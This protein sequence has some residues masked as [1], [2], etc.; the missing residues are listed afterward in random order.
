[1]FKRNFHRLARRLPSLVAIVTLLAFQTSSLSIAWA[2]NAARGGALPQPLPLFPADN[3]WNLD[4]S[5]WPVDSNSASFISFINNGGT[6][7]LH[8]DFGGNAGSGYA[9]Y[10]M[11]YA[12]VTSVTNADLKAVQ[13]DY[14]DESDGVDHS[15]NTSFPFY[16]IPSEAIT[17]P[18]WIEGGDPGN[19]D[20]RSSEDRHLLIVDKDRNYLYELYNVF[21][22]TTQGKWFAGSG[23]FFD[24]NTNSRRPDG[25]TSADAAGLAILPGLV[26]YDEVYDPNAEIRHALRVTVRATNGYVYPASHRAGS[27]ASAL[28][29]G[30]RLRLKAS[31][32]ITQRTGDPNVQK[33]FRA[34]QKYG[35][36]VADNGSDMYITGT[37][38]TRWNNDILNPAF[39]NVSA[40][41]FEVIQLGY[42]PAQTAQPNLSSLVLN[43]S[44]ITGGQNAT[45]TVTL[46]ATAPSGSVAV[47]LSSA[48]SAASVPSSV[49]IPATSSS[50]NF[51]ITTTAV[52]ATTVGNITAT[53]S[54][55][56]KSATLTVNPPAPAAISSLT[57][58]PST[59]VGGSTATGTV[60]LTKAAPAGGIVVN[61]TSSNSTR[62]KVP[63]TVLIPAG[64]LSQVFNI[65]TTATK[66]KTNVRITASYAGVNNSATLTIVRR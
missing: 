1:M 5:S 4:I 3:W 20:L 58:S 50:A 12:V 2:M 16:P 63:A 62:A 21:Y 40:S 38:D 13:F 33:I 34:M 17:Q 60:T 10:G 23:A 57:L 47:T 29:M 37:Y 48:N 28:P 61:L 66:Q 19:V 64:A 51:T 44:S 26:R 54:G 65:T 41:D 18:Y 27:T 15:T 8:P 59:I 6:R 36:I 52:T 56:S 46:T 42:N 43:P 24:M 11:P 53:Y 39:A 30:A 14:A 45:G 35:L 49:V 9:I 55:A 7:R 32:D 25:W 31:V 22:N